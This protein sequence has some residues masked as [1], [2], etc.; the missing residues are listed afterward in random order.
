MEQPS[1]FI[2]DS[3]NLSKNENDYFQFKSWFHYVSQLTYLEIIHRL[4]TWKNLPLPE[5]KKNKNI[6]SQTKKIL[7]CILI[8]EDI[9]DCS[10][11]PSLLLRCSIS[12]PE[13]Q[14]ASAWWWALIASSD[15]ITQPYPYEFL[16]T[17]L[18]VV[19]VNIFWFLPSFTSE[20]L[21]MLLASV[22]KVT[23]TTVSEASRVSLGNWQLPDIHWA[24]IYYLTNNFLWKHPN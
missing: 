10:C 24:M 22:V 7:I 17:C 18:G 12:N 20:R 15:L 6:T 14:H 2:L 23:H 4:S 21:F 8:A 19:F 9:N 16:K 11:F 3:L 5:K 1:Q 13:Y